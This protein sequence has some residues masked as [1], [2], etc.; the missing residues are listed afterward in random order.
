MGCSDCARDAWEAPKLTANAH[1]VVLQKARP[2]MAHAPLSG[3]TRE[4][5]HGKRSQG[6]QNR[7][8]LIVND[9][10]ARSNDHRHPME[11]TRP[12]PPQVARRGYSAGR[13]SNGQHG[14]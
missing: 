10:I 14:E 7:I 2:V 6:A 8:I 4:T 3:P 13:Y 9:A 11:R 12:P 1:A 5:I